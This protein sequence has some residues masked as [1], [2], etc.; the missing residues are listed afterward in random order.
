MHC[1][2]ILQNPVQQTDMHFIH[3]NVS[4]CLVGWVVNQLFLCLHYAQIT[5]KPWLGTK[6]VHLGMKDV[7]LGMK[8]VNLGMKDVH[9]GMNDVHLGMKWALQMVDMYVTSIV[10]TLGTTNG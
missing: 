1:Y 9:L 4:Q 10:P 3:L 5:C 8:V 2:L 6:D 7:H